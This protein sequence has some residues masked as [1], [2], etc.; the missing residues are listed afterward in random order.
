MTKTRTCFI[1]KDVDSDQKE[2]EKLK[3]VK[4]TGL[5]FRS[6]KNY[7]D[8]N[9]LQNYLIFQPITNTFTIPTVDT[10]TVIAW[11]SKGFSKEGIKT[12]IVPS[13]N[14]TPKLK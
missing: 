9:G 5:D 4:T 14:L 3:K 12:L 7:L 2:I 11:R 1:I 6:Y 13:N 10:E 8:N